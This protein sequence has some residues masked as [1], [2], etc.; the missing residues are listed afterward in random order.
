MLGSL[1]IS[2]GRSGR[3]T[4]RAMGCL[5]K[6]ACRGEGVSGIDAVMGRPD[7]K[8]DPGFLF[9]SLGKEGAGVEKDTRRRSYA[10]LAIWTLVLPFHLG[11]YTHWYVFCIHIFNLASLRSGVGATRRARCPSAGEV[12]SLTAGPQSSRVR[13]WGRDK[14]L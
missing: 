2:A 12:W 14:P 3:G 13:D 10:T 5:R 4:R 9:H 6:E 8:K 1:A 7:Q 11:N